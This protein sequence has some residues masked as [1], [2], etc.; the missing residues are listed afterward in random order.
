MC[1][2][3]Q[4]RLD[5]VAPDLG[6]P[7]ALDRGSAARERQA[8]GILKRPPSGETEDQ[9]GKKAVARADTGF[10][11]DGKGWH[12]DDTLCRCQDRAARTQGQRNDLGG[13]GLDEALGLRRL[14]GKVAH[15]L[16]DNRFEL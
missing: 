3:C 15:F 1:D 13:T 7:D 2:L 4:E 10:L 8:Q 11:G 16:T 6:C 5:G 12:M 14:A 9:P